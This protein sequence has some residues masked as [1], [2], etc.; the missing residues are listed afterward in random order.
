MLTH[1]TLKSANA[2]TGPIPVSTSS[3]KTCPPSCPFSRSA[4]TG[5]YRGCYGAS[6]PLSVNWRKVTTGARGGTWRTFCAQ[7]AQLPAGQLWRHNQVGD[8]P[9]TGEL[10]NARELQQL[11]RANSGRRG[12]TYT[13]KHTT[14][15]NLDLIAAANRGG[16]TVNLSANTLQHADVLA[17]S[18]AGPIVVTL[19]A[20]QFANTVT[21]A[22]RRVV[23]C[24]AVARQGKP[25]PKADRVTCAT[26][27]LCAR[28]DR[29]AIIGFP[30][31]GTQKAAAA[32]AMSTYRCP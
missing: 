2:K 10:I 28:V 6:G 17:D 30:A 32:L 29:T 8:L 22:G 9:G 1:L 31:H 19:S 14:A 16:F 26:C 23:I 3:A 20:D 5:S 15:R 12:F 4:E 27:Q 25:V 11:T 24:P 13:H 7:V 21:P 18:C